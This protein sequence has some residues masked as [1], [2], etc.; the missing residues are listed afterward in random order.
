MRK[1]IKPNRPSDEPPLDLDAWADALVTTPDAIEG[2][3]R[4]A[5]SIADDGRLNAEDREFARAQV[6]A[7]QR[8]IRR[9]RKPRQ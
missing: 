5:K 2:V 7:I 3:R 9:S 1:H 6:A 8:A 4:Q